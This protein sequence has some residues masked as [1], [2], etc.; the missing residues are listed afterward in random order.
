M[1]QASAVIAVVVLVAGAI[2][3]VGQMQP[4]EPLEIE[5]A[6]IRLVPG[7]GPMAGYMELRN[8]GDGLIR[9]REASSDAFARVM[10]HRTRVENGQAR[11]VHQGDGVAIA[12]GETIEFAPR[13]LHLMLMQPRDELQVGD[14]VEV[15]LRFE[16]LEPADRRQAFTVVPVTAE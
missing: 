14:S 3:W 7:G 2:W 8:H 11:M 13:G 6:R 10:I 4:A 9:L 12:P 5:N 1:K 16:G 15:V